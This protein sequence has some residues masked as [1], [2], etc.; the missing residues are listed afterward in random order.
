MGRR[1]VCTMFAR[2]GD[3]TVRLA[4]ASHTLRRRQLAPAR[5]QV[6][7]VQGEAQREEQQ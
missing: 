3:N 5:D 7:A 1:R 2:R 4:L 6:Q